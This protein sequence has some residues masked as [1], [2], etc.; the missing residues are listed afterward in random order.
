[1]QHS[2]D[3]FEPDALTNVAIKAY[4]P[5][6]DTSNALDKGQLLSGEVRRQLALYHREMVSAARRGKHTIAI[7]SKLDPGGLQRKQAGG[8]LPRK[9]SSITTMKAQLWKQIWTPVWDKIAEWLQSQQIEPTLQNYINSAHS[10]V[11]AKYLREQGLTNSDCTN[12]R[13]LLGLDLSFS[14]S[15]VWREALC[16]E[17][18]VVEH[19]G[20]KLYLSKLTRSFKRACS[21]SHGSLPAATQWP[22]SVTQSA[23]V[24]TLLHLDK[25]AERLFPK[26]TQQAASKI[27]ARL[28]WNYCGVPRLGPHSMRTY[29]CCKAVNNPDVATAD[30]PALAS[31]MQVS[32]DTMNTIYAAPSLRGPAAQLAFKL[33]VKAAGEVDAHA[34]ANAEQQ[35]HKKQK[36]EPEKQAQLSEQKQI[37]TQMQQLISRQQQQHERQLQQQQEQQ[38]QQQQQQYTMQQHMNY[39]SMMQKHKYCMPPVGVFLNWPLQPAVPS[40]AA[41]V[42][43][44]PYGRAVSTLRHQHDAAVITF[45]ESQG[46]SV[47]GKAPTAAHVADVFKQLCSMRASGTLTP[48]ATWFKQET[49]YFADKHETPFKNY[50]RKLWARCKGSCK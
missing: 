4:W 8:R 35:Q 41:A 47:D 23:V 16:R 27:F 9:L 18:S 48:E 39:Q 3:L 11:L 7:G 25:R 40:V 1:M 5:H 36:L 20:S 29:H 33:H 43:S 28:G 17:C 21:Q 13:T 42:K 2:A 46:L 14:R 12:L 34:V 31:H 26:L 45:F 10:D 24:H 37:L 38:Q 50:V 30:Y 19:E 32:V 15:Q 22:L 49:T 44:A 6:A